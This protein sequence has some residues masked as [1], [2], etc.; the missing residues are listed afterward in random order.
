MGIVMKS[1][2]V[3]LALIASLLLSGSGNA[4]PLPSGCSVEYAGGIAPELVNIKLGSK[5]RELCFDQFTVYHSGITATPLFVSE[6]LT[7]DQIRDAQAVDREDVFHAEPSLPTSERAEL[8]NYRSS[9]FDRG[10]MAPAADMPS[11]ESQNQSFSLANMIPQNPT[12][13]RV[14]WAR[15]EETT[16]KLAKGYGEVY[17]VTGPVFEGK[18]I[19]RI[20]GRVFVPTSV[21]KAIYVPSTGQSSAWWADNVTGGMEV[22]S[23][24]ELTKRVGADV[25]PAVPAASKAA[26]VNLPVPAGAKAIGIHNRAELTEDASGASTGINSGP[27]QGVGNVSSPSTWWHDVLAF[28]IALLEL[29][30]RMILRG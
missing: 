4:A 18:D 24:A 28:V 10:H 8:S 21:Y 3:A 6:H 23:I 26:L 27:D 19:R 16:R 11:R 1:S 30:A 5:L 20:G 2:F 13:N 7:A 9:G 29:L 17:V 15:I 12:L 14:D 22:V 25:F